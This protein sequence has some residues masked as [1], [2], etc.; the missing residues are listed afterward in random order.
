M[1]TTAPA[2]SPVA[3]PSPAT[4]LACQLPVAVGSTPGFVTFP[5]GSFAAAPNP[6]ILN[7]PGWRYAPVLIYD[8]PYDRWL[9]APWWWVSSDGSRYVYG[10]NDG[11]IHIATITTGADVIIVAPGSSPSGGGWVPVGITSQAVYIAAGS[12]GPAV[13][14]P[15]YG[16]WSV[17]LDGTGLKSIAQSGVWTLIGNGAAWGVTPQSAASLNRLDLATGTQV[18]WY[19]PSQAFVSL[20]DVDTAGNPLVAVTGL[21]Q[22]SFH[23]G[24]VTAKDSFAAI[25]LPTQ[26][27][28]GTGSH[29]VQNALA[30]QSA[31]WLT[32]QDGSLLLSSK[33]GD[34]NL[35]ATVPGVSN[36]G[37]GCY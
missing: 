12:V 20:Y 7:V 2:T 37:A 32:A 21:N 19:A 3:S 1:A 5:V 26:T 16:L 14:A 10:G 23:V 33:G 31:I 15:F 22:T 24:L 8:R 28:W 30:V 13:P 6:S 11:S 18:S 17:N 35:A 27:S 34:F 29:S 36:V 9:T 4:S 25:G